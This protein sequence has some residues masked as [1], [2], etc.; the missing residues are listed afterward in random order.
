MILRTRQDGT[1]LKVI[2]LQQLF[3]PFA[4]CLHGR[5]QTGGASLQAPEAFLK[6]DLQFLSGEPLPRCWV[7]PLHSCR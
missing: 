3:D 5:L 7:D 6:A 1:R 4:T 2:N